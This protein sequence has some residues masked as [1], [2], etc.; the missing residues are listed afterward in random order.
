VS[1]IRPEPGIEAGIATRGRSQP[2]C[3]LTRVLSD[4]APSRRAAPLP[5]NIAETIE[6]LS[7]FW[8]PEPGDLMEGSVADVGTLKV[9]VR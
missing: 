8:R 3:V 4:R 7:S 1:D 5:M 9:E 2:G 6:H